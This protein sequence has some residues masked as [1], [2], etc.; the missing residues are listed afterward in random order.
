MLSAIKTKCL[1]TPVDIWNFTVCIGQYVRQEPNLALK[2]GGKAESFAIGF[3]NQLAE[4]D[5]IETKKLLEVGGGPIP[6]FDKKWMTSQELTEDYILR[7]N[8]P[9]F[10]EIYESIENEPPSTQEILL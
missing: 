4:E 10:D 7:N 5:K 1:R 2:A 8:L 3:F 6:T 9:S